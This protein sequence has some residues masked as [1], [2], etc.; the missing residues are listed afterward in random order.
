MAMVIATVVVVV[1]TS[2]LRK[3]VVTQFGPGIRI[4]RL[5]F[6]GMRLLIRVRLGHYLRVLVGMLV[7]LPVGLLV[8]LL[9]GMLVGLLVGMLVGVLVGVLVGRVCVRI[10]VV[11]RM[12]VPVPVP[13]R[14]CRVVAAAFVIMLIG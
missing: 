10:R 14:V 4:V 2:V 3:I 8:G 11:V 9:V 6:V 5:S 12:R 1:M 13:M 7:G